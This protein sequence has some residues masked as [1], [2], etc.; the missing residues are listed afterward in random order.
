V[1]WCICKEKKVAQ[2]GAFI[3]REIGRLQAT[4]ATNCQLEWAARP[5][6]ASASVQYI[7]LWSVVLLFNPGFILLY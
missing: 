6:S 5:A 7:D 1:A 4:P 3:K 2:N